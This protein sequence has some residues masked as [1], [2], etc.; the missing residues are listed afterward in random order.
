VSLNIKRARTVVAFYPDMAVAAEVEAA[1]EQL[2]AA[3][4]ALDDA[5]EAA[6]TEGS[7]KVA[8]ARKA[9]TAAQA[10]YDE[11]KARADATVLD[12]TL[13]AVSRKQWAEVEENHP[14]RDGDDTDKSVGVN[15][16][17]FLAEVLPESVAE[18]KERGTGERIAVSA[19][20]W[21]E[22]V[23]EISDGQYQVLLLAILGLN[24]GAA[25]HPF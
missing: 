2:R 20:D 10:T 17:S 9:V 5:K 15:V 16:G 23:D 14:P 7:T 25:R 18:V 11:V 3:T 24:R 1:E 4:A 13:E 22:A 21:R 12:V 8:A 6:R 19:D